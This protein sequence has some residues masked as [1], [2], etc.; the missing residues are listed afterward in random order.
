MMSSLMRRMRQF[1]PLMRDMAVS[2]A[3][4][5]VFTHGFRMVVMGQEKPDARA[6]KRT[7]GLSTKPFAGT[8]AALFLF[9]FV[10]SEAAATIVALRR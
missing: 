7:D 5:F 3:G 2:G 8:G 10:L 6:S 9:A 4:C 1:G